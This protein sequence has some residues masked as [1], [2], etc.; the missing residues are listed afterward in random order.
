ML[1][2]ECKIK[3]LTRLFQEYKKRVENGFLDGRSRSQNV[4]RS[5]PQLM[6]KKLCFLIS[7]V[8][9]DRDVSLSVVSHPR[10]PDVA[11]LF[12]LSSHRMSTEEISSSLAVYL[13]SGIH[14][15]SKKKNT[16][17][18]AKFLISCP[19]KRDCNASYIPRNRTKINFIIV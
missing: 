10:R 14:A 3:S 6:N 17:Q 9:L 13:C 7:Q 16:L 19:I 2:E 4:T 11:L 18:Q 15:Q 8:L 12:S 5:V 1:R